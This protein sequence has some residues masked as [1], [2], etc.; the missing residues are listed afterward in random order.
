MNDQLLYRQVSAPIRV[1][2]TLAVGDFEGVLTFLNPANGEIV[3]RTTLS[4]AVR[5]PAAQ[6][7][8]GAVFQTVDGE[9]AYIVQEELQE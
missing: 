8:Y 6:F 3:A 4:D 9:V 1:G 5:T 2:A 7:G